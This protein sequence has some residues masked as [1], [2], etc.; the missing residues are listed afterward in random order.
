MKRENPAPA[1]AILDKEIGR[2]FLEVLCD[3]GVFK[4]NEEG[5]SAFDRF[6]DFLN[7]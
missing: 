1:R 4:R 3:A 2:V 5:Q 6:V 7:K